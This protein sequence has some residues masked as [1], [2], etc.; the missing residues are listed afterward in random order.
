M[1]GDVDDAAVAVLPHLLSSCGGEPPGA[2][3]VGVQGCQNSLDTANRLPALVVV[4]EPTSALDPQAEVE[5]FEQIR[6]LTDLG[7]T[8]I[9]ITHRLGATAKADQI[10]VLDHGRL[11]EEGSHADLMARRPA[12]QYRAAYLLQARQYD[13]DIPHQR[14]TDPAQD[15]PAPAPEPS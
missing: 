13:T 11:L 3:E 9:L 7:I 10:F 4:D 2:E 12:T 8:V 14:D 5:A 6:Q 15:T 1:A